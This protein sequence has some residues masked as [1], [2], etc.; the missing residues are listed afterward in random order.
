MQERRECVPEGM[1]ANFTDSGSQGGRLNVIGQ[2]DAV[3]PC[4]SARTSKDKV[5]GVGVYRGSSDGQKG[6]RDLWINGHWL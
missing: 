5:V 3:A 2:H 6:L 4:L 1:P